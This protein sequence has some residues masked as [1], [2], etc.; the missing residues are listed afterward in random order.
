M[1]TDKCAANT[2]GMLACKLSSEKAE[3]L[4]TRYPGVSQLTVACLNGIDDCVVSGPLA[5]IDVFQEYCKSLNIKVKLLDV[6]YAFHSLAMDPIMEPLQAL[7]RSINFA[8]PEIPIFSNVFGRLFEEQDFSNDYF[9]LH[10]RQPVRFA[11]GLLHLQS[12]ESLDGAVFLEMGPQPTTIPMVRSSVPSKSCTY[13]SALKKGQDAWTSIS[14]TLAAISLLQVSVSWREV[15]LGTSAN[16]TSLP[17]H[18]LFGSTYM[19]PYQEPFQIANSS[20]LNPANRHTKTGFHLLPWLKNQPSLEDVSIFETTS[21]ILGPLILGHQVRGTSICPASVFREIALEA[22]QSALHILEGQ[23]LVVTGMSFASP[24]IY[25]PSQ[26]TDVVTVYITKH[27][28]DTGVDF[29]I[30][31]HSTNDRM[32]NQHCTGI[33]SLQNLQIHGSHWRRDAAIIARQS[34]YFSGI[35]KNYLS[36]FRSQVLYETIFTR[37]VK[38]SPEYQSLDY[39]SVADSNLEGIGFFKL[40]PK[41]ENGYLAPPVFTDTLL[42]AA[43]FIANLAVKSDEA[44]ICAHVESI[45]IAYRDINYADTFTV[46]FSLLEIK[47][48]I[49]ADA[50]ALN[51][52]GEVVAVVRGME[53][54]RLRLSTFQQM[55]S[56]QS[57]IDRPENFPVEQERLALSTGLDTPPTIGDGINT[58][59]DSNDIFL[60]DVRVALKNIVMEFGGFSEQ[61]MDYT[62]SLDELG[63]DYLMQIEIISKLTRMFPRQAGLDHHILSECE[64]LESLENTLANILQSSKSVTSSNGASVSTTHQNSCQI[65]PV[66]SDYSSSNTIHKVPVELH[67]SLG[68]ASPLCLFHDGS[69]QIS[70][71]ERLQDHDRSTYAFFDLHFG[72][73]HR[74]NDSINQMAAYYVSLLSKS[75]LSSLI[76]GGKFDFL[77]LLGIADDLRLVLWWSGGFRGRQTAHGQRIRGARSHIDRLSKSN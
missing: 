53:F 37:V 13:L 67:V 49:L 66:P 39:L 60:H 40:R 46:Y 57:T 25:L 65:T 4:I 12:R 59:I 55:L 48:A 74:P 51:A 27:E 58:P 17:G 50:I 6:P 9:A 24:L 54:K 76:V 2:S 38:Y 42:H 33:V 32:E 18:P 34:H 73:H 19:I 16:V 10:A 21:E 14:Q 43:G 56:R 22:A 8:P 29:R 71:Y 68:E 35:G 26:Q 52:L 30:T 36:T 45:E 28:L 31:S 7:G 70:M 47:G 63:I 62:K 44:G 3:E 69:G 15:F 61:D 20:K 77:H 75:K 11:E 1:M 72:T 64:T 23:T 41:S 5:E